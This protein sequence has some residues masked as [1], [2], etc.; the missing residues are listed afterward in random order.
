MDFINFLQPGLWIKTI[1]LIVIGF[2]VVF[3][4][5]VFTQAKTMEKILH[6][7]HAEVALKTISIIHIILAISL[8][9]L[10]VVIL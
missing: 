8:F 4:L 9:G 7:P 2:Y 6:L 1:T 5:V 10:A 3:T